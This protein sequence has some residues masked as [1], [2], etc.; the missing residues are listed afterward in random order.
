MSPQEIAL[1]DNLQAHVAD[2]API[3]PTCGLEPLRDRG[4]IGPYALHRRQRLI[5][6]RLVHDCLR[7]LVIALEHDSPKGLL[8]S[9]M[10]RE[11]ALGHTRVGGNFADACARETSLVNGLH[12]RLDNFLAKRR[13][14]PG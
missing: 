1:L 2:H 14:C 10:V 8:G 6:Q 9:E 13:S 12:A 5:A 11:A 7:A 3:A 4:E